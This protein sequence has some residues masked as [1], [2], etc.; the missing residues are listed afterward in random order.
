[1]E[2]KTVKSERTKKSI[3]N[4]AE[5]SSLFYARETLLKHLMRG[6]K[7]TTRKPVRTQKLIV[8]YD[9]SKKYACSR[10][11]SAVLSFGIE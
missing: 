5:S 8:R 2:R 11:V 1:M 3:S 9:Y 6:K 10:Q 4:I 7:K